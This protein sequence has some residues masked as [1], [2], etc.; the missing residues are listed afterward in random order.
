MKKNQT[1]NEARL[2]K[3]EDKSTPAAPANRRKIDTILKL[4]EAGVSLNRFEAERY[5]DHCLNSTIATLRNDYYLPIMDCREAV[6]NRFGGMTRVK[7]YWLEQ[8]ASA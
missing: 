5:G 2:I 7:R 3:A 1:P 4:L 6:P 8:E